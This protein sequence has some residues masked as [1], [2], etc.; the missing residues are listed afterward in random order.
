MKKM[1]H[2]SE[3]LFAKYGFLS[4]S[5]YDIFSMEI[6][7]SDLQAEGCFY[8][9]IGCKVALKLKDDSIF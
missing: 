8:P 6:W 9:C 7:M 4:F 2:L 1:Q 5:F 3:K